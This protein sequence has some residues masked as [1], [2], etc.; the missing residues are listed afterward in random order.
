MF[1]L[2]TKLFINQFKLKK[3]LLNKI[4]IIK[5]KYLNY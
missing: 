1:L 2:N 3:I 5:I 4:N